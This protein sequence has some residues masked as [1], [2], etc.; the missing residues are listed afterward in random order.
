MG[1]EIKRLIHGNRNGNGNWP[2]RM[3][4]NGNTDC[5]TA[6]LYSAAENHGRLAGIKLC[7]LCEQYANPPRTWILPLYLSRRGSRL[8]ISE[9][10]VDDAGS[11]ECRGG[12][13]AGPANSMTSNVYIRD[14][15][16]QKSD[17]FLTRNITVILALFYVTVK[18]KNFMKQLLWYCIYLFTWYQSRTS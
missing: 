18:I 15:G 12:N 2:V 8:R 1:I 10:T 9:V 16:T 17:E 4:G 14:P 13:V 6:H 3:G 5:V 11:Y 7:C